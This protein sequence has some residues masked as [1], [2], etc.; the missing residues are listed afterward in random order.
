MAPP[1]RPEP[2]KA[3]AKEA[4]FGAKFLRRYGLRL[5][6]LFVGLVLYLL[7]AMSVVERT[8]QVITRTYA[9]QKLD[10]SMESSLR[11][12]LLNGDARFLAP[13]EQSKAEAEALVGRHLPDVGRRESR[14]DRALRH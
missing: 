13:Y 3:L 8:D 2:A 6:L 10:L 4:R 12:F 5:F 1:A 14:E 9:A 11:G 7:S